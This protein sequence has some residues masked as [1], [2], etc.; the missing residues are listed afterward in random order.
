M[1]PHARPSPYR[2]VLTNRPFVALWL[3]QTIS[4]FGD[5][6]YDLALLWYV[7]DITGSALAAGGIAIA[8]GGGRLLGSLVAGVLLDRLPARPL[9]LAVELLRCILTAALGA[10]WLLG[11]APSLPPLYA[12]A[13]ALACGGALFAPARLAAIPRL[14]ARESLLTANALDQ[15][16]ASLV[17]TLAW[18]ASG[19]VVALLGPARG[20]LID[21][22]T[23]LLSLL[24]IA[25]TRWHDAPARD[26]GPESPLNALRAGAR[27][28]RQNPLGRA[29]L[30]AQLVQACAGAA[31]F[32]GIGLH[33]QRNLGGDA[34]TYGIQGTAFGIA[35]LLG[36]WA[37]GQRAVRRVGLLYAAGFIVNGIG[38]SGFALAPTLH[39][40][41]PAAFVAGLGAAAFDTGEITLLQ[42]NVPA[43][44]RGRVIALTILLAT[45]VGMAAL[46]LGGWLADHTDVRTVM[47]L[48]SLTHIAIGICLCAR[49][50]LRSFHLTALRAENQS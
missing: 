38:N 7:L 13:C 49:P 24:A 9:M 36:S 18:G 32:A 5:T 6:L 2:A 21:A 22:A 50:H 4:R 42:A 26:I 44:V 16:S 30:A 41:L 40:L 34:T 48:A 14:V 37:I 29:I 35:L 12:L 27:W 23:F 15:L 28:L 8:A 33:L 19:A 25:W 17:A 46:A 31:F 47:L 45:V 20:L 43:A 10:S 39:L 1:R 3:G 11:F